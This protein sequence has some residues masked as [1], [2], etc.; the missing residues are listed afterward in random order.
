[1]LNF[2]GNIEASSIERQNLNVSLAAKLLKVAL[3]F[4]IPHGYFSFFHSLAKIR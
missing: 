1:M 2:F 3:F 4:H